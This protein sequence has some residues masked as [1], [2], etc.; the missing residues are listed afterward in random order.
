M[1]KA[2]TVAVDPAALGYALEAIVRIKPLPGRVS[3]VQKL[4]QD[5]KE[6]TACDNVT[7][8]DCFVARMHVRS[9]AELDD[10]ID[11]ITDKAETSTS[12]VKSSPV[13]QKLPPI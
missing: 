5:I 10:I 7:G 4:I 2:F 8:D 12:I 11:R 6:F 13:P 1:I 9:V 3:E